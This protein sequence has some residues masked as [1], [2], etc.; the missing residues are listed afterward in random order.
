[1]YCSG[2]HAEGDFTPTRGS[3][4]NGQAKPCLSPSPL[5]QGHRRAATGATQGARIA[6]ATEPRGV[7]CIGVRLDASSGLV[8]RNGFGF[9]HGRDQLKL[10]VGCKEQGTLVQHGYIGVKLAN[11]NTLLFVL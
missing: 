10:D 6:G 5:P 1:M 4:K 11:Y 3:W 2:F 8:L 7:A 9:V